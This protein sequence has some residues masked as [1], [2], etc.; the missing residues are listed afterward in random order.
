MSQ[1]WPGEGD[2]TII[3]MLLLY[4]HSPCLIPASPFSHS[5]HFPSQESLLTISQTSLF[6]PSPPPSPFPSL[7]CSH[8]VPGKVSIPVRLLCKSAPPASVKSWFHTATARNLPCPGKSAQLRAS[9]MPKTGRLLGGHH[10][11]NQ[12]DF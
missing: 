7:S 8:Q 6:H 12:S 9:N 3:K 2:H 4:L 11:Y 1:W 5:S 10:F